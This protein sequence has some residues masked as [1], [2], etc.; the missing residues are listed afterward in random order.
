M[1]FL[2]ILIYQ[3]K[4][5]NIINTMNIININVKLLYKFCFYFFLFFRIANIKKLENFLIYKCIVY[6]FRVI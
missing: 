1:I 5:G 6:L 3:I 2:N 4:Y